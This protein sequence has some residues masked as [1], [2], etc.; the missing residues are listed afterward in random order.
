MNACLSFTQTNTNSP[1][2]WL[3]QP[4]Y[5]AGVSFWWIN[6]SGVNVSHLITLRAEELEWL[7]QAGRRD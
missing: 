7:G 2:L 6:K 4:R 3:I 5:P 1:K